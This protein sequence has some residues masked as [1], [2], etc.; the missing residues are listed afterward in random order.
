[1]IA[2]FKT[3]ANEYLRDSR[4]AVI[5]GWA[6]VAVVGILATAY[7]LGGHV[8]AP[9]PAAEAPGFVL[10]PSGDDVPQLAPM[11]VTFAEPPAQRDGAKLLQLQPAVSGQPA[12]AGQYAWLTDR[13]LL[14][15]PDYPGLLRGKTYTLHVAAQADAGLEKDVTRQFT[16]TGALVVVQSIPADGDTEVPANAQVIVQFSRS[17]APLTLLSARGNAPVITFDPSL[18]GTGEWLNTSLYRF[19]PKSLAPNT[20]YRLRIPAGLTSAADGVLKADYAWSFTTESPAVSSISPD[21]Q[22][23]FAGPRQPVVVVFNQAMDHAS[24]EAGLGVANASGTAVAGTIA[25]SSG[26]DT[27][28]FTPGSA[29]APSATYSV[30]LAAGL[31]GA[32]GGVTKAERVSTFTTV[33]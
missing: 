3:F 30:T 14:F 19:T 18:E 5:A 12:V 8:A 6:A 28:T 33:G 31:K 21:N 15:Q 10:S 13:T 1:M 29:L 22:S 20:T 2:P 16:T 25:W 26:S 9:A 4:W 17:V 7:T 11:K 32:N 24:V 27:A 23:V